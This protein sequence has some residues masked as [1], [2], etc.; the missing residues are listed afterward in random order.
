MGCKS[1]IRVLMLV[2]V[3]AVVGCKNTPEGVPDGGSGG[4]DAGFCFGDACDAGCFGDACD[5]DG[6][7]DA[8]GG[9]TGPRWL[10]LTPTEP[11][12]G[13]VV[14]RI[15]GRIRDMAGDPLP[16]VVV[17]LDSGGVG[18]SDAQGI[19][20]IDDV[21]PGSYIAHFTGVGRLSIHRN[22]TVDGWARVQLNAVLKEAAPPQP[23]DS[24]VGA[25]LRT[26]DVFVTVPPGAFVDGSGA[27]VAGMAEVSIT[28]V[29]PTTADLEA[30][31]GDY[32]GN[33]GGD[34]SPL[35]S[36]GM[37][38]ITFSQGGTELQL[39]PG[40]MARV[41]IPVP[42]LGPEMPGVSLGD[43]MPL[44]WFDPAQATWVRDGTATAGPA[45]DGSGR[46]VF[47]ADVTHFTPWNCDQPAIPTCVQGRVVDCAG[48]PVAGA[49]IVMT[50]PGVTSMA[51]T[52]TDA[53]GRYSVTGAARGEVTVEVR[54]SAGVGSFISRSD[55]IST[56]GS[57]CVTAPDLALDEIRYVGGMIEVWSQEAYSMD[58]TEDSSFTD[59][60]AYA[61]FW[62]MDDQQMPTLIHCAPPTT[63]M[64][65]TLP[66]PDMEMSTPVVAL[67]VG[68]PIVLRKDDLEVPI[69]RRNAM[70]P[71]VDL[72]NTYATLTEMGMT[73]ADMG[74]EF[75]VSI[76]G[77]AGAVPFTEHEAA[78]KAPEPLVVDVPPAEMRT[79]S[80]AGGF[81]LRWEGASE[82]TVTVTV[83]PMGAGAEVL[84]GTVRDDGAFE[85]TG[86]MLE[87]VGD[88]AMVVVSRSIEEFEPLPS[89]PSV[90]LRGTSTVSFGIRRE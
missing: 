60:A 90:M 74:G 15:A 31:P 58:G 85:L 24:S 66:V 68:N 9:V 51:R 39:A 45:A 49:E 48:Y 78:L 29:D 21:A 17:S 13:P 32:V 38:E 83:V 28:P 4:D 5:G 26:G 57:E 81:P 46:M 53:D 61:L 69:Y 6:D 35:F 88:A 87:A 70:S 25:T 37:A 77:A 47:A 14:G 82:G 12:L 33:D 76:P 3:V 20:T 52:R 86:A 43:S 72:V 11:Y 63:D 16:G 1:G 59:I 18:V 7:G 67:D 19:Y 65:V 44:W 62:D 84:H 89:G 55:T 8:G 30:A 80:A 64:V 10:D 36:Y 79:Y 41:E 73:G 40:Q 27:A 71:T 2:A 42:A 22:V 34:L 50:G 56:P 54:V 23:F 75:D